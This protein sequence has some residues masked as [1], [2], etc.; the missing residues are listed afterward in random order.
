[1][2]IDNTRP[3]LSVHNQSL[4]QGLLIPLIIQL[5]CHLWWKLV[6][7]VSSC[8][9][10]AVSCHFLRY[11]SFSLYL[12][13]FFILPLKLSLLALGRGRQHKTISTSTILLDFVAFT[14]SI[15]LT[16]VIGS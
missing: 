9:L 1:M 15:L 14:F 12:I 8:L 5:W 13:S 10:L 4:D 6:L 3:C 2:T 7:N 11:L 16:L